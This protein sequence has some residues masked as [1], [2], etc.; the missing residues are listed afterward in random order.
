M[1]SV[2]PSIVVISSARGISLSHARFQSWD[3]R[4]NTP[5]LLLNLYLFQS[6]LIKSVSTV[7]RLEIHRVCL[8]TF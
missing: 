6:K 3:S 2:A 5:T 1:P 8:L 7:Y 4:I